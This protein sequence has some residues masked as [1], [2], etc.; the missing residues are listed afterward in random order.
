MHKRGLCM[1]E[2][3]GPVGERTSTKCPPCHVRNHLCCI[4]LV[5][6]PHACM[7]CFMCV[8]FKN[9]LFV[10][11]AQGVCA[12]FAWIANAGSAV[13][14]EFESVCIFWFVTESSKAHRCFCFV[15]PAFS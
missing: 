14:F 15:V 9:A 1:H 13:C 11:G 8:Q 6:P 3:Q 4:D 7:H 10:C 12:V 2:C 5:W